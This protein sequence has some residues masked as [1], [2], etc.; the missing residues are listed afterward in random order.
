[1]RL[2]K[3]TRAP[4][5]R[6]PIRQEP[7]PASLQPDWIAWVALAWAVTFSFFYIEMLVRSRYPGLLATVL[8]RITGH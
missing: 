3:T 7:A 6:L 8:R 1:M 2:F 4:L 5:A